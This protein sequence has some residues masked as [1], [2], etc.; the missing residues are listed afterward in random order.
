ME[1]LSY[2][3][4]LRKCEF[5]QP[6]VEFL[7]WLITEQEIMVDPSKAIGLSNWPQKLR[8]VKEV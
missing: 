2:S 4:K 7:G 1:R 3:L 5:E 6:E 8:N